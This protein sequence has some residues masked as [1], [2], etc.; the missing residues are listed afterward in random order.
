MS[1]LRENLQLRSAYNDRFKGLVGT[2]RAAA[3]IEKHIFKPFA[4]KYKNLYWLAFFCRPIFQVISALTALTFIASAVAGAFGLWSLGFIIGAALI[5]ALEAFKYFILDKLF[6]EYN[7]EGFKVWLAAAALA[8]MSFSVFSSYKG[9]P[10]VLKHFAPPPSIIEKD[11]INARYDAEAA[12]LAEVWTKRKEEAKAEAD[13]I[14][15]TNQSRSRPGQT[16]GRARPTELKFRK[17]AAACADSL[18]AGEAKINGRRNIEIKEAEARNK[19]IIKQHKE[20]SA[21]YCDLFALATLI[22]EA[23][24]VVFSIWCSFYEFRLYLD[25]TEGEGGQNSAL[26][27]EAGGLLNIELN[28]TP[29]N[30][31][32]QKQNS[33]KADKQSD[34][35]QNTTKTEEAKA[36]PQAGELTEKEGR[37]AVY[38]LNS[39]NELK[40]LNKTEL[41]NRYKIA[42]ERLEEKKTEAAKIKEDLT[43]AS[44]LK[45]TRL[46]SKLQK[47]TKSINTNS[48]AAGLF[49]SYLIKI[50]EE[51]ARNA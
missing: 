11:T 46:E 27:E 50:E 40:K 1:N 47:V 51:A 45:K 38:Y 44:G 2:R 42:A 8:L 12:A 49:S 9:A 35:K 15:L 31:T 26:L 41:N 34:N 6:T 33:Y 32:Q 25:I 24:L 28:K 21:Y 17:A 39:N 5:G 48:K 14:H 13:K 18:S 20:Q 23:C 22:L 3:I 36:Q 7:L 10:E 29:I 37:P 16:S 43:A 30:K 4:E 19:L